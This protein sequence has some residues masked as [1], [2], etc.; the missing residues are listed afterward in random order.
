MC[1][2]FRWLINFALYTIFYKPNCVLWSIMD[3]DANVMETRDKRNN[4]GVWNA[5]VFIQKQRQLEIKKYHRLTNKSRIRGFPSDNLFIT[6]NLRNQFS[7]IMISQIE[8]K[9]HWKWVFDFSLWDRKTCKLYRS[10]VSVKTLFFANLKTSDYYFLSSWV[11]QEVNVQGLLLYWREFSSQYVSTKR[12]DLVNDFCNF[13][14]IDLVY[15]ILEKFKHSWIFTVSNTKLRI[16]YTFCD[17]EF[18]LLR[19]ITIWKSESHGSW[20]IFE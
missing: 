7:E 1:R 20:G 4:G 14:L 19:L 15:F 3:I 9:E 17:M 16:N 2:R 11:K 5:L 12:L 18:I 6:A 13:Q 10:W 8:I